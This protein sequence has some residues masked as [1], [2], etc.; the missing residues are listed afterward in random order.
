MP[1]GILALVAALTVV[2]VSLPAVA[3]F[4][5]LALLVIWAISLVAVACNPPHSLFAQYSVIKAAQLHALLPYQYAEVEPN[6]ESQP[7]TTAPDSASATL[8]EARTSL[9]ERISSIATPAQTQLGAT[10]TAA[11]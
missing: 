2:A 11:A 3:F 8:T 7:T 9:L 4:T 5:A 1:L 10:I 6:E